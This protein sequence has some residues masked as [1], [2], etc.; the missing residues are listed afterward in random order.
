MKKQATTKCIRTLIYT[1]LMLCFTVNTA[2]AQKND[3]DKVVV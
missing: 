1:L 2:V 3:V